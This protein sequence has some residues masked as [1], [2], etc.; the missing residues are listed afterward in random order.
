MQNENPYFLP[1]DFFLSADSSLI[2][3]LYILSWW[4]SL[5]ESTLQNPLGNESVDEGSKRRITIFPT[6]YLWDF[7][8]D[9]FHFLLSLTVFDKHLVTKLSSGCFS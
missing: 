3:N 9:Y 6:T 8:H 5:R 4:L 1:C 7:Y 2:I